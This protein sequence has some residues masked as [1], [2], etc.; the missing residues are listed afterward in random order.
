VNKYFNQ[1]NKWSITLNRYQAIQ[2]DRISVYD[3]L[4]KKYSAIINWDWRLLASL[5]YQESRFNPSVKSCRGAY[6]LM[7]M[8]PTT[9]EYFGIDTSAS[10]EQQIRAGVQYIKFLDREFAD[11]ITDPKERI[12]FIL[13]SY[14]IGPGHVLDAQNLAIKFGKNP[15]KWFKNV[16]TCLLSKSNPKQY[17]DPMVQYGYCSGIETFNFVREVLDR[18]QHY[19]NVVSSN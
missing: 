8:M 15:N 11:K 2:D 17:N 4:L 5:I 10:P 12:N 9:R 3:K 14:N 19:K 18:Y 6:G 7:Q 16:D 13:A 1:Q